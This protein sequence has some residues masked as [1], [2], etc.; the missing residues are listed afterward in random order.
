MAW[1]IIFFAIPV[2]GELFILNLTFDVP[3]KT[4]RAVRDR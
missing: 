3:E 4:K 1:L 2:L